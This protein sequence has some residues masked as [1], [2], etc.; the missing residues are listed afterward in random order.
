M[1]QIY[2]PDNVVILNPCWDAV[3]KL[4]FTRETPRSRGALGSLASAFVGRKTQVLAVT[5]NEPP[6]NSPRDR[7]IRFDIACKLDG[8]EQA[9]L[10]MTLCPR[11]YEPARLEYR[12]ARLYTNQDIKGAD[13]SF[14]DLQRAYQI[15]FFAGGN[16]YRDTSVYSSLR[17]P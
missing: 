1:K 6:S 11:P 16:L 2:F 3:F 4:I 7:Q 15:S 17:E 9:N 12:L 14:G 8:G 5:P 10:E 13:K